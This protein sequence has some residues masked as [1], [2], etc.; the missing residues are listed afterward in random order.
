MDFTEDSCPGRISNHV[1]VPSRTRISSPSCHR[2]GTT[3]CIPYT[4]H[5]PIRVRA[6]GQDYPLTRPSPGVIPPIYPP[7][8]HWCAETYPKTESPL[9]HFFSLCRNDTL[10]HLTKRKRIPTRPINECRY[11]ERLKTKDE[12][13]TCLTYTGLKLKLRNLIGC[14]VYYES[15][16]RELKI[17]PISECQCD[18]RLKTKSEESTCQTCHTLHTL[19]YSGNWNT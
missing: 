15:I 5:N 11:N 3:T 17:K 16:K 14:F 8:S 9:G 4:K 2:E 18:E 19:T 13:F 12:E 1:F 10:G 6:M 7:S